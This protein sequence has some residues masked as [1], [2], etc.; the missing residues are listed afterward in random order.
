MNGIK[1]DKGI[2]LA[3]TSGNRGGHYPWL[4]MGVGDSFFVA[5]KQGRVS[6][7]AT[8]AAHRLGFRFATRKQVEDGVTGTRVWRIE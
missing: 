8:S 4:Q 7:A 2:P 5:I 3:K 6:S 1:I